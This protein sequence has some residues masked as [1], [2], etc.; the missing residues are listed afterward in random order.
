[1]KARSKRYEAIRG[2]I[3]V[4]KALVLGLR[5][6]RAEY[7][8]Q[9]QA[10]AELRR[11]IVAQPPPNYANQP[12]VSASLLLD[13][14]PPYAPLPRLSSLHQRFQTWGRSP[15]G[16]QTVRELRWMLPSPPV[17]LAR[18]QQELRRIGRVRQARIVTELSH[19]GV[20]TYQSSGNTWGTQWISWQDA[21]DAFQHPCRCPLPRTSS[22]IQCPNCAG[23]QQL[24]GRAPQGQG[25]CIWC[26]GQTA[27]ECVICSS[28]IH[29]HDQCLMPMRGAHRGFRPN[30]G[31]R[32]NV[33]HDC[34]W[35]WVQC[36]SGPST[37]RTTSNSSV[38]IEAH[39]ASLAE[40]CLPAAG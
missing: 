12:S 10:W 33:C 2:P 22:S 18:M 34:L 28:G 23:Y 38:E 32:P 4:T 16:T 25:H 30:P 39:M 19:F 5:Y 13:E 15:V 11:L 26:R 14:P 20:P 3:E 17:L 6:I 31:T 8:A 27:E 37:A 40:Q 35:E 1:M 7:H 24:P 36:L 21:L 9:V 29:Y